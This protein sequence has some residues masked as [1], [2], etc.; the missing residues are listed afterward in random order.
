VPGAVACHVA[1]G[2]RLAPALEV[3]EPNGPGS[4]DGVSFSGDGRL[5]AVAGSPGLVTV[6]RLDGLEFTK[7]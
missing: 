7:A 5:L 6:F 3:P 1:T 4:R 2:Q